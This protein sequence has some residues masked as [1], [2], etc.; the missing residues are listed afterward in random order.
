MI[1]DEGARCKGTLCFV[2]AIFEGS[3]FYAAER[4][5]ASNRTKWEVVV[6]GGEKKHQQK[7]NQISLMTVKLCAPG[8]TRG[9]G[10][11]ERPQE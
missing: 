7:K 9:Q 11:Q 3:L 8:K 6:E 10:V 2:R 1:S 5:C 4:V